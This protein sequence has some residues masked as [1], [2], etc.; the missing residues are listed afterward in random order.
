[1]RRWPC[2]R[3]CKCAFLCG[4]REVSYSRPSRV[5]RE[6]SGECGGRMRNII[7]TITVPLCLEVCILDGRR[8]TRP[9]APRFRSI[10]FARGPMMCINWNFC[11]I[12]AESLTMQQRSPAHEVS[13][14]QGVHA[15][16][17]VCISGELGSFKFTNCLLQTS[18][19]CIKE[20]CGCQLNHH[21]ATVSRARPLTA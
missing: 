20:W 5:L 4:E 17:N 1:M 10:V 11:T 18:K 12:R 21:H 6:K 9:T 7:V 15:L 2:L 14:C 8:R 3:H 19:P 16:E 13:C